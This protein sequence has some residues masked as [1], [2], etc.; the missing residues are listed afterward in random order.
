MNEHVA[1]CIPWWQY[2][3]D[4]YQI[5][6]ATCIVGTDNFDTFMHFDYINDYWYYIFFLMKIKIIILLV[7]K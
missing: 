1:A 4:S 5:V 7:Y 2:L 6:T 3:A